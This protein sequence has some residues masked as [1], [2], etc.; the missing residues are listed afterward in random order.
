MSDLVEIIKNYGWG[1]GAVV[2]SSLNDFVSHSKLFP[3]SE[4]DGNSF[5]IVVSQ[6]CDV[7]HREMDKEP[8]CELLLARLVAKADGNVFYGKNPRVLQF[9]FDGSTYQVDAREVYFIQRKYLAEYSPRTDVVLP[10][11]VLISLIRWKGRRYTRPAFPDAFGERVGKKVQALHKVFVKNVS[12]AMAVVG[13]YV[14]VT[15][16]E[17]P[18]E[19]EYPIG[20]LMVLHS[21][22]REQDN[23]E[24]IEDGADS[25][26]RQLEDEFND[27]PGVNVVTCHWIYSDCFSYDSQLKCKPLVLDDIS[28][29][30]GE[31]MGSVE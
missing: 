3:I 30:H 26:I 6:S 22:V 27:C 12:I 8:V 21:A 14:L 25:L 16:D 17:L 19:I 13:V 20:L 23:R 4:P 24:T 9:T 5:F 10:Q 15:D 7:V 2:P 11:S 29:R 28:I 31:Y 18:A 1:Q